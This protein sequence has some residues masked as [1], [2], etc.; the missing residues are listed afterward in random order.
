MPPPRGGNGET[1]VMRNNATLIGIARQLPRSESDAQ[2][3]G[4][5]DRGCDPSS[6]FDAPNERSLS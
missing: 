2:R 5:R 4:Q 6:H 1:N 3:R